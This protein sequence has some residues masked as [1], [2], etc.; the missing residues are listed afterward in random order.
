MAAPSRVNTFIADETILASEVNQDLDDLF[1]FVSNEVPHTDG[2]NAFTVAPAL[3]AVDPS[4]AN[5]A[6]RK[7]YVDKMAGGIIAKKEKTT[8]LTGSGAVAMTW[9]EIPS[10]AHTFGQTEGLWYRITVHL[11]ELYTSDTGRNG[12][13]VGIFKTSV[14]GANL[15][16]VAEGLAF[17][18]EG[19]S[20]TVEYVFQAAT[21]G[22]VTYKVGYR[23]KSDANRTVTG[24]AAAEKPLTAVYELVGLGAA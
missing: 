15:K 13:S 18:G 12:V 23:H 8:D 3:P 6:A 22:S 7:A 20:L 10:L 11:P 9:Y 5:Q 19:P 14:S 2:T 4:S 24:P 21:T 17:E 16:Q 1:D